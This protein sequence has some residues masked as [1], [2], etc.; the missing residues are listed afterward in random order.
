MRKQGLMNIIKKFIEGIINRWYIGGEYQ[1]LVVCFLA[2]LLYTITVTFLMLGY[3]KLYKREKKRELYAKISRMDR[4]P[5][6]YR[7]D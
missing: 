3:K 4:N 6:S 2:L 5:E 1:F 7:I